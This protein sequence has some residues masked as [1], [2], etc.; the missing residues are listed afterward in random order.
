LYGASPKGGAFEGMSPRVFPN[1][2]KTHK[3]QDHPLHKQLS[4]YFHPSFSFD[5]KEIFSW[6]HVMIIQNWVNSPGIRT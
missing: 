1:L 3:Y 5:R 6:G 4:F 2:R